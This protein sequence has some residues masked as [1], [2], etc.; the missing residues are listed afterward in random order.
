M[1][2]GSLRWAELFP[3]V[4]IR[5]F[6]L[7]VPYGRR[8]L[9]QTASVAGCSVVRGAPTGVARRGQRVG[10]RELELA[11]GLGQKTT[12][13]VRSLGERGGGVLW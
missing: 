7:T 11:R 10:G 6:V 1:A 12:S 8:L 3:K 9:S 13:Q 5:Q 4:R 2:E